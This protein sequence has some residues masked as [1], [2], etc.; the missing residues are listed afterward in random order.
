MTYTQQLDIYT[1]FLPSISFCPLYSISCSQVYCT[2]AC[3]G[4]SWFTQLSAAL[5][6]DPGAAYQRCITSL[7][8]QEGLRPPYNHVSRQEVGLQQHW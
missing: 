8:Q 3:V 6:E 7:G 2:A 1:S 4:V 5:G